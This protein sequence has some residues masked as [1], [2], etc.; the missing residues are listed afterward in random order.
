M[1]ELFT[2]I[3]P[4]GQPLEEEPPEE[5]HIPTYGPLVTHAPAIKH[6]GIPEVQHDVLPHAQEN[7]WHVGWPFTQVPLL[8]DELDELD[9][10]V[11]LLLQIFV[12]VGQHDKQ[13]TPKLQHI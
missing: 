9:G 4:G 10:H 3:W 11:G 2:K 12:F 8:L 13:Q 5:E 1:Q 6:P 7:P